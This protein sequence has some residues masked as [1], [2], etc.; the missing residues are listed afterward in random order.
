MAGRSIPCYVIGIDSPPTV[1]PQTGDEISGTQTLWIDKQSWVFVR[2]EVM[3]ISASEDDFPKEDSSRRG[4]ATTQ[5]TFDTVK[6]NQPMA[7]D[8]FT[9]SPPPDARKVEAFDP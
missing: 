8:L 6:L 3:R 7:D 2:E 4:T 5:W 9:F 1:N